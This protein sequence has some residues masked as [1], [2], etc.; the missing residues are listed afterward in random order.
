M[1]WKETSLEH[2]AKS[3]GLSEAEV[4]EKQRLIAMITE[5][6]KKK[7]ISQ[8]ALAR[9]LDVSQ[10]RI[11]QIESGIG[12]RTVSFDVLFNIL[13]I[14]GYDFHIVYRKVA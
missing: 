11:A 4:R 6:R 5:I 12:T 10:G 2:L 8:E 3:L 7:G 1:P 9:K 13:A 14:L